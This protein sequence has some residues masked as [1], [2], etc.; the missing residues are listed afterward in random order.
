MSS[1]FTRR[2]QDNVKEDGIAMKGAQSKVKWPLRSLIV[3]PLRPPPT[4]QHFTPRTCVTV[5]SLILIPTI[6]HLFIFTKHTYLTPILPWQ[7]VLNASLMMLLATL[8]AY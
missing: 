5:C 8:V 7:N 4:P 1:H 6:S 2:I 3:T